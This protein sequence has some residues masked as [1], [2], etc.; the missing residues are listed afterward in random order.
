MILR[1]DLSWKSSEEIKWWKNID[2]QMHSEIIVLAK[3][4]FVMD[5]VQNR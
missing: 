3:I 5:K 1:G 2:I 4:S